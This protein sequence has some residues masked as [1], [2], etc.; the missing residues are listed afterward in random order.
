MSSCSK[1]SFRSFVSKHKSRRFSKKI[2]EWILWWG[3]KSLPLNA[4]ESKCKEF[5]IRAYVDASFAGCKLTRGSRTW[6]IVYHNSTPIYWLSKKHGSYE[7]STFGSEFAAMQ[8]CC[9]YVRGLR[10]T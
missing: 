2:L 8:Q 5:I 1:I 10:Y 3:E 6:F 9:K 4:S 7:I